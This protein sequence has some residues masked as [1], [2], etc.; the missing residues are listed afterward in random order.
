MGLLVA[1]G[2]LAGRV[3]FLTAMVMGVSARLSLPFALS[4]FW[5][6][7]LL[8]GTPCSA[9]AGLV[10]QDTAWRC[11]AYPHGGLQLARGS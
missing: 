9:P 2:Q 6:P 5:A 8:S 1:A 7:P 4:E 10:Q 11:A 3:G